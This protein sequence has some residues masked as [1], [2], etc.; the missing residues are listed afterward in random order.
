MFESLS[1]RIRGS[2]DKLRGRGTITESDLKST[3]REI[4]MSLIEADVNFEVAKAFVAQVQEKALGQNVLESLSPAEQILSVVYTELTELLGGKPKAPELKNEGNI[5][6]LMG[7][8][9]SGKTTTAG[10]LAHFYKS[11]ARRPL[12]I[13][14]DTQRPAAQ[15][16]LRVLGQRV[17]VP[18]IELA[19]GERPEQTQRRI[20]DFLR[21]DFRDLIIVDTAGRLQIDDALMAELAQ[22]RTALQPSEQILVVDSMMGQEA[23]AV[24]RA[25]DQQIGVSGLIL[26]K[27]DG[28]AR[29]GAALSARYVTGKPVYFAGTSEKLEGLEPFYPDRVAS[30]I[31]EMGD[32]N[33]LMERVQRAEIEAPSKLPHEF[34]LSDML[35]QIQQVRRIGPLADTMKMIPGISRMIP[36]DFDFDEKSLKHIEALIQSMTLAERKNPKILNASRRR[37]IAKG[38][39]TTVQEIN[40][41][42]KSFEET[43][44]ALKGLAKNPK[45]SRFLRR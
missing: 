31:L 28:D 3:L 7:L 36:K 20:N 10:K 35:S 19:Q 45:R 29:G 39:G 27:L 8:Q 22:L 41:L 15:E 9:G 2:L 11:K 43:K 40:Q 26:T 18:V 34:D 33:T 13:A 5:I 37:R 14:A 21:Q 30:R 1:Q 32:L 12:L 42:V 38:S 24:A 23:L 44:A 16:Q 4:R 25:F 6:F 17:G